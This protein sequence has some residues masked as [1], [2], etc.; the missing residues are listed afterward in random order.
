MRIRC[1]VPSRWAV[2]VFLS[3]ACFAANNDHRVADAAKHQNTAAVK[4]LIAKH[5]D[6]NGPQED[7]A[8]ALHWAAH[9]DDLETADLLI[10]GGANVN[11]ANEL[12]VTPLSLA[13]E[14]G[15]AAMV[16]TLL[17]AHANANLAPLNGET[18]LMTCS[19]AGNV[20]AVK[21][22]LAHGADVNAKE[23]TEAQTALMWAVAE[24][25]PDV[26]HVLIEHGADV[27]ARS[28]TFGQLIVRDENGSRLV[29]PPPAGV[30]APCI[31]AETV[32]K[33]GSTPLLFAARSGDVESAKLLIA[34]GANVNEQAPDGDSALVIA[35]YSGNG[36]FAEFLLNKD[37]NPGA[38]QGGYSA[39]HVALLRDDPDLVR[40]LLAHGANPNTRITKGTPHMRS[41]QQF[42]LPEYLV[43]ATPFFLAA[44][45]A[46][47]EMMR[48][49]VAAGANPS[50]STQDGTTPLMAAAGVDYRG[51]ETRRNREYHRMPVDDDARTLEAVKIAL[52]LGNDVN[53]SNEA[54]NTALHG[55][56]SK[57]YNDVIK[58]LVEKGANLDVKNKRGQTPLTLA[59]AEPNRVYVERDRTA[60]RALLLQLGAKESQTGKDGQMKNRATASAQ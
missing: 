9:W 46:D 54:G 60:T 35:A 15:S 57:A 59:S 41:S 49:L 10:R 16:K 3:I 48:E 13:C 25:H 44:K 32:E 33:G 14:N 12:G 50:I 45:Y 51:G 7:G 39:L 4:M 34:A 31:N 22:L 36:K 21:T 47:P 52:Q 43:G 53:A 8:T 2:S 5:V 26:V 11:A 56:A 37:A 30:K 28:R 29:C 42:V 23:K 40:S 58:L 18:P 1:D 6:V 17:D 24:R 38:D 55:A 20:E 27:E 19:R